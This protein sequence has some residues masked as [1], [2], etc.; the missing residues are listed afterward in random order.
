MN[1]ESQSGAKAGTAGLGKNKT[2][3]VKKN[4]PED[5]KSLYGARL[6]AVRGELKR[7]K[8]AALLI[9][10]LK[11]I[12]YL[13]GFTG[14]SAFVVVTLRSG[15]LLTDPRYTSQA[16]AEVCGLKVRI[17][18]R[19]PFGSLADLIKKDSF[20]GRHGASEARA[21]KQSL[22][23]E[24]DHLKHSTYVLLRRLLRPIKLSATTGLLLRVRTKKDASELALLRESAKLLTKGF[25]MAKRILRPGVV[26]SEAA[27]KIESFFRSSGAEALA[28]DTIIASGFRGALPHGIASEK[29][30]KKGELVVVDMGAL[31]NGYNSDCTR[32]F[33]VGKPSKR[34]KEIYS[35]VLEGQLRAVE[36]ARPGVKVSEVDR[37]ARSVIEEAGFGKYFT[38]STGHGVGLDIHEAPGVTASSEAVLE[39]GMVITVE[40]GIYLPDVGGVRIEDMVV[41][42]SSGPEVITGFTKELVLL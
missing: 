18:E 8:L 27:W 34:Q 16:K 14:S 40:P 30:I 31:L 42:G 15:F 2:A 3:S 17:Y 22:G 36:M 26:E 12:K 21:G 4:G 6:R 24:S 11:N 1:S 35:V 20:K 10:D 37:A 5:L 38:H 13:T 29:K 32:T 39:E 33:M 9:T 19:D 28:F 7:L 41:V 25:Q 23:F